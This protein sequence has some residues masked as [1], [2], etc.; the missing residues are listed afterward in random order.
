MLL[1]YIKHEEMAKSEQE[2]IPY[3]EIY[4]QNEA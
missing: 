4:H 3:K 2:I 1:C